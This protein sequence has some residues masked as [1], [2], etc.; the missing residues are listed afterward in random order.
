MILEPI[1]HSV[2]PNAF[3]MTH[4]QTFYTYILYSDKLSKFYIGSTENLE[5]RLESHNSGLSTFT[6]RAIPWKLVYSE[7]F[8][9]RSD[10]LKR[11]KEIKGKKSRKYIEYLIE[12]SKGL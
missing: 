5:K 7:Q 11:E 1:A 10:S 8:P 6:S 12:K 4:N 3:G 9:N 2:I